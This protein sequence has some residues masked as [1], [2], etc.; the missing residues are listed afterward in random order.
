MNYSVGVFVEEGV[1]E[2][3]ILEAQQALAG[4]AE[5]YNCRFELKEVVAVNRKNGK[6]VL[7]ETLEKNNTGNKNSGLS[8]GGEIDL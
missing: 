5:K 7:A 3:A 2:Q 1:K 4:V 8:F 6:T